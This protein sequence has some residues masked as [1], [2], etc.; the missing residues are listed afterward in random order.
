[1]TSILYDVPGPRTRRRSRV[2]SWVVGVGI[3]VV[4]GYAAFTLSRQGLFDADRW[5]IF[6]DPLVWLDLLQALGVTLTAALYAAVL[7]ILL[8]M[9]IS[10]LRMAE[11]RWIRIPTTIVLEFLRGMPVLLMMLFI[12]LV[13]R[14]DP[15]I[16]VVGG[17]AL[18]NGAIIGEALRSGIVALPRGQRE[19]GLAMGL[20]SLQT[21]LTIEFPQAFRNMTPIIVAQ[22]VVLLKDTSLGY[23]VGMQELIRRGRLMS[24]Y[25]GAG[26][27][28]FSVFIVLVAMY[29]AVN[30]TVSFIARR[31]ARRRT[32][33]RAARGSRKPVADPVDAEVE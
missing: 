29:L 19:A 27:Y 24:E 32:G 31:L 13:F 10:L 1:M 5:D 22:L 12:V 9:L 30:L 25:F 18:Y 2:I 28:A 20:G 26:Q 33:G 14:V 6:N 15:F 11:H 7:A 4:V 16:G 23:I 8:G 17:L 3:L 21:R